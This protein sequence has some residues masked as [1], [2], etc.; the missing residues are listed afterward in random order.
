MIIFKAWAFSLGFQPCALRVPITP[1]SLNLV[2]IL[3]IVDGENLK[4]LAV[5]CC[6]QTV[7]LFAHAVFPKVVNL[8][9]SLLVNV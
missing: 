1:V 7:G 2:M 4:F 6:A 3:W 5:V 8:A 9:L